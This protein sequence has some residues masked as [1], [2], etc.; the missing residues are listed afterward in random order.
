LAKLVDDGSVNRS[1]AKQ[2][3]S[4]I[5]ES[6]EMPSEVAKQMK[7]SRIDDVDELATVI[8]SVFKSE[9]NA[10]EDA[11]RNPNAVNFIFGKVMKATSGR[12][13]PKAALDLITKKLKE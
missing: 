13:D 10:V 5:T 9:P 1:T 2:I 11:R 8:D 7:A 4:R 12:A 6:G 3:L